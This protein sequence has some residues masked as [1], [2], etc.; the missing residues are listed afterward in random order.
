MPTADRTGASTTSSVNSLR[1]ETDE[2]SYQKCRFANAQ[3]EPVLRY[4]SNATA[5]SSSSNLI[6]AHSLQGRYLDVCGDWPPLW[7]VMRT[8]TSDVRP[9]YRCLAWLTLSI[10]Y[11]YFITASLWVSLA[12]RRP[13]G[14]RLAEL[15]GAPFAY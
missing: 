14:W 15:C 13:L 2:P 7:A 4:A 1:P 3:P 9:M 8:S 5:F 11:T 6:A 12:P 10:R